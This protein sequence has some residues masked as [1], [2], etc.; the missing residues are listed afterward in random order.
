MSEFTGEVQ[1]NMGLVLDQV[2]AGLP[3]GGDHESRR[4]VAEQLIQAVRA[5]KTALGEL[6]SAGRRAVVYLKNAPKS[7]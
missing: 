1:A 4:Y 6:T 7:A 2:C 3:N 5:G